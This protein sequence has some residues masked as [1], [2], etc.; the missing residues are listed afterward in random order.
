MPEAKDATEKLRWLGSDLHLQRRASFPSTLLYLVLTPHL[1][2]WTHNQVQALSRP[3]F[4]TILYIPFIAI[5]FHQKTLQAV[6]RSSGSFPSRCE[7]QDS[8][9][10]PSRVRSFNFHCQWMSDSLLQHIHRKKYC[11]APCSSPLGAPV[12][13]SHCQATGSSVHHRRRPS[14][15]CKILGFGW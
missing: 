11:I 9:E 1:P 6:S 12:I 14:R 10:P 5:E 8:D 7:D 15:W 3:E 13:R 4:A 2:A